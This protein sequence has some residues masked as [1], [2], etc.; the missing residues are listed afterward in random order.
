MINRGREVSLMTLVRWYRI[1]DGSERSP[2]TWVPAADLF[3]QDDELVI[4][5]ELPGVEK[6]AIDV[7]IEDGQLVVSAER[8]REA[9]VEQGNV[10]R[11]ERVHGQF[12][13]RFELPP[14]VDVS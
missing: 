10:Y 13:R 8:K 2:E 1:V 5:V 12:T 3:E 4:R 7:Q 14:T 6:D 9:E 11:L